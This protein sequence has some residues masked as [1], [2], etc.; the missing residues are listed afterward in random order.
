M[1]LALISEQCRNFF[2]NLAL[3]ADSPPRLQRFVGGRKA[4]PN[5]RIVNNKH[6]GNFSDT[7]GESR[8]VKNS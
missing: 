7:N 8:D 3:L 4:M 1:D 6:W 2:F 5:D